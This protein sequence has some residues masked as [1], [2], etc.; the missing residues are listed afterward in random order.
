MMDLL[1]DSQLKMKMSFSGLKHY[2]FVGLKAGEPV[3][4][5]SPDGNSGLLSKMFLRTMLVIFKHLKVT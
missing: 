5:D 3:F 4:N 1:Q 2:F